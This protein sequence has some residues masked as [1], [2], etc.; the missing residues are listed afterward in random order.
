MGTEYSREVAG[1]KRLVWPQKPGTTHPSR[2]RDRKLEAAT[3]AIEI[4]MHAATAVLSSAVMR[5]RDYLHAATE[6]MSYLIYDDSSGHTT[7]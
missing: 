7:S 2:L 3:T 5:R 4:R 1:A 6:H